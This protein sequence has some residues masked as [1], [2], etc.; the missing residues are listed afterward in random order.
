MFGGCITEVR[1]YGIDLF[2]DWKLLLQIVATMGAHLI[3]Y[4]SIDA[5]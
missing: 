1:S 2:L 5:D 4:M 3:D